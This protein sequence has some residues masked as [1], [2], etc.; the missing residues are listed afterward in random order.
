MLSQ[1]GCVLFRP[2][3]GY[4]EEREVGKKEKWKRRGEGRTGQERS[5]RK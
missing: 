1:E 2:V 5:G 4:R 3:L